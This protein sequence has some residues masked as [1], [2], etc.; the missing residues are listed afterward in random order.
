[1]VAASKA[2]WSRAPRVAANFV[3]ES[4]VVFICVLIDR[5]EWSLRISARKAQCQPDH[6]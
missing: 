5:R 2:R 6:L 4:M 3:A 1:M